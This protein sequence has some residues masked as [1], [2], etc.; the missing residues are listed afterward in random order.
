VDRARAIPGV[1]QVA[2][3]EMLPL[4]V[5]LQVTNFDIPGVEPPEGEEHH[6]VRFNVI[7]PT[8]FDVMEIPMVAGRAFAA[9]DRAESEPV[10]IVSEAAAR[11]YWPGESPLG[12]ILIRTANE[13]SYRVVGVAKDTKTWTLGEEFQPYVYL[14]RAQVPTISIMVVARGSIPEGEIAGQLRR[15]IRDLDSR[16]VIMETKTMTEHLSVQLFPPRAAAG[17]LGAFGL[18]ALILATTGLYGTVAF[19]V[20]RRTREMGIRVSLGADSGKVVKMVLRG[21]M[22]LVA[23]GGVFGLLL[24]LALAQAVR[25]FLYGTSAL[26]PVTFLGVP[27]ILLGVAAL[28]AFVPARKA[29]RV[30]PVEALKTE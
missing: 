30:N 11:R 5:A 12:K 9:T 8:F 22:G 29:S 27:A 7:S 10:A 1:E 18:L 23:V 17:L 6:D 28:A 24:S 16:L 4:G 20:S 3:G 15:A 26:D 21:A 19:S 25:T 14:P 2:T 13:V